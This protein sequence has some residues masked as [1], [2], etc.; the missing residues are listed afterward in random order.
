MWNRNRSHRYVPTNN[1]SGEFLIEDSNTWGGL[2]ETRTPLKVCMNCLNKLNYQQSR[3][4]GC[5]RQVFNTFSLVEFFTDYSTCFDHIPRGLSEAS[6]VGYTEDWPD[7]S[8]QVRMEAGYRCSQCQIDLSGYKVLCDVHHINGVKSDNRRENLQVLCRDCHR[9]QPN[10]GG[11][12]IHHHQMQIINQLRRE[13]AEPVGH[14]WAV[15]YAEA[16]KAIHGDLSVLENKGY[17]PPIVGYELVGPD[18]AVAYEPLE[19]AWP[20]RKEAINLTKVEIPGWNVF[21]VGQI[22]GGLDGAF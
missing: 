6:R 10:H 18:G 7:I 20:S 11:I 16:D 21:L 14:G 1:L 15:V 4:R 13:R 5:V 3:T 19:A 17:P 22:C 9:K 12:F 8:R 2:R